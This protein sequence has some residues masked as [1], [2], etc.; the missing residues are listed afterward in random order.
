MKNIVIAF[1]IFALLPSEVF[2]KAADSTQIKGIPPEVFANARLEQQ[3]NALRLNKLMKKE[4]A[5]KV[6]QIRDFR[7][8]L[9]IE[10]KILLLKIRDN[11]IA[12]SASKRAEKEIIQREEAT[13]IDR[14]YKELG[15]PNP[16]NAQNNPNALN[17]I[18]NAKAR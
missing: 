8:E 16:A 17:T 9:E 18:G 10:R 14:I 7:S 1:L 6:Q 15:V 3:I 5:A 4:L 11:E 2:A 13:R 12:I